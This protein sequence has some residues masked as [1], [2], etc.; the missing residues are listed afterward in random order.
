MWYM[1]VLVCGDSSYY[2]GITNNVKRRLHE[3]N[4]TKKGA[5]YTKSRRPV[6]LIYIEECQGRSDALKKEYKFKRLKRKDKII[7]INKSNNIYNVKKG[8]TNE[9]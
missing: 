5:K 9:V 4:F 2:C 3:H 1:Y 8:V 6:T 7:Y